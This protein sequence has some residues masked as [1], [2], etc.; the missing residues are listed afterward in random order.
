MQPVVNG[1]NTALEWLESAWDD[2]EAALARRPAVG[3]DTAPHY[4]IV[5]ALAQSKSGVSLGSWDLA[6]LLRSVVRCEAARD[7]FTGRRIRIPRTLVEEAG[8][9]RL[10][11]CSVVVHDEDERYVWISAR[12]WRPEWLVPDDTSAAPEDALYTGLPRRA[13]VPADADA[14]LQ[15]HGW[16]AYHSKAQQAAVRCVLT[17]PPGSTVVINLPTGSGKSLCALLPSVMQLEGESGTIGVTP[18]VVPTVA[19]ALDLEARTRRL[20]E[21]RTAYRPG[22]PEAAG[23][24]ARSRAGI[25]GPVFLAPEAL[26]GSM[27][28]PLLHAARSGVLNTFV[29]DEAHMVTAWGDDFR[30]AFQQIAASRAALLAECRRQFVTVLMSATLTSYSQR[31]LYS[32]FGS[33]GPT[34]QVH[35]VRLRP[36]P[37]YWVHEAEDEQDRE[38]LIVE[39]LRHLPR[40]LILYVTRRRDATKW[41]SIL[42]AAGYRRIG[43]MHG[44]TSDEARAALLEAWNQDRVDVVVATSAFG[45]G[46]DKQDVRAV[47]HATCPE[48]IDR[49]Y[50]DVGRG[51]R[52]GFASLSLVVWTPGDKKLAK[53]LAIPTFI[54]IERGSQRWRAMFAKKAD[55]EL[56]N[57]H[58]DVPL[59]V[60]PGGNATDIDMSN[61][62]NTRWNLRT[63]LLMA[64]ADMIDIHGARVEEGTRRQ[65]ITVGIH[66]LEHLEDARWAKTVDPLRDQLLE[67]NRVAWDEMQKVLEGKECFARYFQRAYEVPEFAV[68]VVRACGGCPECRRQLEPARCGQLVGRVSPN[69]PWAA[70]PVGAQIQ[71]WL[72]GRSVGLLFHPVEEERGEALAR[73][74][75]W[76]CCQGVCNVV[77][78]AGARASWRTLFARLRRRPLLLHQALPRGVESRQATAV[79]A[80]GLSKEQWAHVWGSVGAGVAAAPTIVALPDDAIDPFHPAR[81]LRDTTASFPR[82]T[83]AQWQ[84]MFDE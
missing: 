10:A 34:R 7:G 8:R 53:G 18:V 54:G 55:S 20:V 44:D 76:A 71:E 3:P 15:A 16:D 77:L 36:E 28:T 26:V 33:P 9:H 13:D 41:R 73:F 78:S 29:V 74:I 4:R 60:S 24:A 64:R 43:L 38:R 70:L 66:D 61:D 83:L 68:R 47:V 62:E 40:P 1:S 23:I 25:Q 19:L 17:A 11:E 80:A 27:M 57:L 52:D 69:E 32:F 58:Y 6:V 72:G 59:D 2:P 56:P 51:G 50:Q 67:S 39:A 75:A 49:F 30:P 45:L 14:S 79:L 5:A 82:L 48:D 42:E 81:L 12:S 37:S 21:H 35:A 46:V 65:L 63:L 84:E 22:T 31:A